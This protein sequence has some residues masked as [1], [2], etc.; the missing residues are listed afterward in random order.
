PIAVPRLLRSHHVPFQVRPVD[1]GTVPVALLTYTQGAVPV[2]ACEAPGPSPADAPRDAEAKALLDLLDRILERLARAL[3]LTVGCSSLPPVVA[4]RP[5][6]RA[7]R[8][9]GAPH[10]VEELGAHPGRPAA[11]VR[12]PPRFAGEPYRRQFGLV[13]TAIPAPWN[14][15]P[16]RCAA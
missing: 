10:P 15:A 13:C 12:V 11:A 9:V 2:T 6:P 7:R 14:W 3:L 5:Q 1:T 8:V 4:P 16:V